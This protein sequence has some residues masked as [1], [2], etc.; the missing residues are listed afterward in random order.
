M[1]VGKSYRRDMGQEKPVRE[2]MWDATPLIQSLKT[3][4]TIVHVVRGVCMWN[5][6]I[7]A[8]VGMLN[9]KFRILATSQRGGSRDGRGTRE[10]TQGR[11]QSL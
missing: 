7:K 8:R 1:D 11:L 10:G 2:G 3:H 6:R 5:K 4:R 9:T